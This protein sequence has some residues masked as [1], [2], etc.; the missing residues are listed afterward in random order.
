MEE[1]RSL[2]NLGGTLSIDNL[3]KAKTRYEA[4]KAKLVL[5]RNLSYLKL[6]WDKNRSNIEPAEETDVLEG[7]KPNS[8]LSEL[9]IQNHG[10]GTCPSWLGSNINVKNLKLL[11]LNG[12]SWNTS[13]PHFSKMTR[14]VKLE[15]RD[16]D[17][18]CSLEDT[19]FSN[20]ENRN[21]QNLV[22]P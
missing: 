11:Y 8:S 12:V 13:F 6:S 20:M 7:M 5:K 15:L 2:E 1:L 17:V 21:F 19:V 4:S 10:G 18:L 14:L 9:H 16:I 3:E 22:T